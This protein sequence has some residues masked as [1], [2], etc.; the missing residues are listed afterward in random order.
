LGSETLRVTYESVS[1]KEG[2]WQFKRTLL[3]DHAVAAEARTWKGQGVREVR[4]LRWEQQ[5]NQLL[6]ALPVA[7]RTGQA[8]SAP[9]KVAVAARLRQISDAPNA[10]LAEKLAMGSGSYVS[11]HTGRLRREPRH[12]AAALLAR[13]EKAKGKA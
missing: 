4:R 3:Q 2:G 6:A 10:W 12:P 13:L 5:L 8:K 1:Q 9:W 11:K 7:D